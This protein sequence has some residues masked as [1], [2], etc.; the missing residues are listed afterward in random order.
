MSDK[1]IKGL[2]NCQ[3]EFSSITSNAIH[4][5]NMTH[6]KVILKSTVFNANILVVLL[7]TCLFILAN[8]QFSDFHK[9]REDCKIMHS[10]VM[11][12]D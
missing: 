5:H 7:T 3:A 12:S 9:H 2:T 11:K 6:A 4:R 8:R 10:L 1:A